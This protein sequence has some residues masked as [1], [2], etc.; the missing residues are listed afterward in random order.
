MTWH[1]HYLQELVTL[2]VSLPTD[3]IHAQA[4]NLFLPFN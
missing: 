2:R 4:C 1:H 3:G